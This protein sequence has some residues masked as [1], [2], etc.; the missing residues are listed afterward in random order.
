M[1]ILKLFVIALAGLLIAACTKP[2]ADT[3]QPASTGGSEPP[4][5]AS[6]DVVKA[7]PEELTLAKGE[8]GY[9][10]VRLQI[11]NGYHINA[12][13][14]SFSYLKATELELK[15]AGGISVDFVSYPDPLTRNFSFAPD[16]PLKV[17]EGE[18]IVKPML[19]A[20]QSAETG[21]HNLSAKLRVQACD[22]QVCYAPG[23]IDLTIA[24][25]VK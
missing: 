9:A 25:T 20:A 13:P 6:T 1:K 12:N 17:Y 21:K 4:S 15:P 18:A 5:I 11:Q 10:N 23:T 2:A 7:T 22:D 16:G 14:P 24:V 3:K 8:S 19:K